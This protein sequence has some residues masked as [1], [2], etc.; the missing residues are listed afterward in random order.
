M[1]SLYVFI[2]CE[3]NFLDKVRLSE[4]V[5]LGQTPDRNERNCSGCEGLGRGWWWGVG[6]TVSLGRGHS[7][8][9]G[10][11]LS[12]KCEKQ[13]LFCLPGTFHCLTP[14]YTVMHFFALF[15]PQLSCEDTDFTFTIADSQSLEQA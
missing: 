5:M 4:E 6:M 15:T 14:R 10:S 3:Y 7:R 2:L 8:P 9:Q 11:T 1:A 13:N 12:G